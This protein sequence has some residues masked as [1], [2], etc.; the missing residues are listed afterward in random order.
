MSNCLPFFRSIKRHFWSF[1]ALVFN[2]LWFSSTYFIPILMK[3]NNAFLH[4]FANAWAL[5]NKSW[6]RRFQLTVFDFRSHTFN[7]HNAWDLWTI[8]S[9]FKF[10][11]LKNIWHSHLSCIQHAIIN[12][13]VTSAISVSVLMSCND[14]FRVLSNKPITLNFACFISRYYSRCFAYFLLKFSQ[15]L[16]TGIFVDK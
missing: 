11:T 8:M 12:Y 7:Y 16:P 9:N 1:N 3:I 2:L 13:F 14:V 5:N 15:K 4:I 10:S 6:H